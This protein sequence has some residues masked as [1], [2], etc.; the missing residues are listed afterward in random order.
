M[1]GKYM[2]GDPIPPAVAE[3]LSRI[4]RRKIF[5][6]GA[7]LCVPVTSAVSSAISPDSFPYVA[8]VTMGLMIVPVA[9]WSFSTCPRCKQ[10]FYCSWYWSGL[11]SKCVNCD[12]PLDGQITL[13]EDD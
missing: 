1:P 6:L 11:S 9:Y 10:L 12:V 4:R 5:A 3:G 13:G 8:L 7:M 2:Y